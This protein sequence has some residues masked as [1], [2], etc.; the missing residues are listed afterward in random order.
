VQGTG[1]QQ[2]IRTVH[3]KRGKQGIRTVHCPRYHEVSRS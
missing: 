3:G 2:D 1:G